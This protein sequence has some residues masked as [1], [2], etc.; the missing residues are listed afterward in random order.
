ME[1]S[2]STLREIVDIIAELVLKEKDTE[3]KARLRKQAREVNSAIKKLSEN[4]NSFASLP[5]EELLAHIEKASKSVRES[6]RDGR[7]VVRAIQVLSE[8]INVLEKIK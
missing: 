4:E 2:L 1:K 6:Q 7:K 5:K 8:L 3:L